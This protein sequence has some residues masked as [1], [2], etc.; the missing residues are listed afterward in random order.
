[1]TMVAEGIIMTGETG[2]RM[3]S[4]D[5]MSVEEKRD[6]GEATSPEKEKI[7]ED[8]TTAVLNLDDRGGETFRMGQILYLRLSPTGWT[9]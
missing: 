2:Q 6:P 7:P 3:G 4:A 8:E 5:M 9:P 1:M